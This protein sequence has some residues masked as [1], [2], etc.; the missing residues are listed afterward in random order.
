M[1]NADLTDII[2]T[3]DTVP[4][5]TL[6][7][8]YRIPIQHW[9]LRILVDLGGYHAFGTFCVL[10]VDTDVI[11][12]TLELDHLNDREVKQPEIRDAFMQQQER[13]DALTPQLHG[14]LIRNIRWLTQRLKLT[15][16]EQHILLF[17]VLTRNV[18]ALSEAVDTLGELDQ[19]RAERALAV[20][21]DLPLSAVS[22]ALHPD[23]TLLSAG[24]M[25]VPSGAQRPLYRKLQLLGRLNEAL[26]Q[27]HT[28]PDRLFQHFFQESAPAGLRC[29]DYPHVSDDITLMLGF[30][31]QALSQCLTG[32][33][34]LIYG[35]PG[36][37]K[38]QLARVVAEAL[39]ARL[40]EVAIADREGKP[41]P[42][43]AR[44]SAY[45]LTQNLLANQNSGLVL[46]DEIEDV[47]PQRG[48]LAALLSDETPGKAW[49]NEL[50][51]TNPVP[52]FWLTN[53]IDQIDP[54]YLRRFDYVLHLKQP[55][56]SVRAQVL[57][58][59][60]APY[61]VRGHWLERA[62]ATET[63][64]PAHV[65]R[66]SR[67]IGHLAEASPERIEQALDRVFGNSLEAM[68]S[69]YTRPVQR[70]A[71]SLAYSLDYLNPDVDLEE[72]T[73]GMHRTGQGRLC[74]YGPPGTGKTAFGHYLAKNLD[75]PC[76]HKRLSDL[77]GPYVGQTEH[78]IAS[79][80]A[81]ARSE[82]AVL[83][84]DEIDSLLHHR[85]LGGRSWEINQVNEFLTQMETFEGILITSTNM[86]EGLDPAALRRFDLKIRFDYLRPDQLRR[87]LDKLTGE[88]DAVVDSDDVLQHRIARLTNIT[89]GDFKT[90]M[91]QLGLR[92]KACTCHALVEGL[93][94]ELAAKQSRVSQSI[95][96][97]HD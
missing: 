88:D 65:E 6:L 53:H 42:G 66:A 64:T 17:L 26:L 27:E 28:C 86:M 50:I 81:E 41:L 51:E 29:E 87:L 38:T 40:Y 48:F 12:H 62:A 16:T 34:V 11:F 71:E 25:R 39:Q 69:H 45:Q 72:L 97:A 44:F 68:G 59:Y 91:R 32:V 1:H 76:V 36:T 21:L 31:E 84:I 22:E 57:T 82:S 54:A 43:T 73:Q 8:E 63:L 96:F 79:A 95:G 10:G 75:R 61:P 33:N 74:L 89:P 60:L 15:E 9:M 3:T 94:N 4:F 35:P 46:F 20:I 47:F 24:L 7:D 92:G 19:S 49:I 77:L 58:H 52:S 14:G 23:A 56:R 55:P 30:L 85:Q 90:V 93:E 5:K 83:M 70:L 37:G 67:V 18:S 2:H 13:I 80:F 78:A